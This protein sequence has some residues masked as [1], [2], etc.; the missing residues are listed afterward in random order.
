MTLLV[1][2]IVDAAIVLTF[3]LGAV[4]VLQR[5]S[6]A[7]RH[8]ILAT[9][10][11]A[12]LLM[13][14][15]EW[16]LPPLPVLSWTD[17]LT[18]VSAGVGPT[19]RNDGF[20]PQ[21]TAAAGPGLSWPV[22]LLT[23][24]AVGAL[25]TGAG[26]LT[27]LVRLSRLLRRGAPVTDRRRALT[28]E[29]SRECGVTRHVSLVQSDDYSVLVTCGVFHPTIVLP[30]CAS[31]WRDDRT[32]IIL[33]HELAHIRRYD[34]AL[35]VAGEA[36]CA[37]HWIN[38]LA[39]EACRRLRHE[40]EYSCDDEVLNGGVE[41]TEYATHLLAVAKSLGTRPAAW[42][43]ALPIA[44]PSTLERRIATMFQT[45]QSRAP[46]G[47]RGWCVAALGALSVSIPLAAIA[48][49]ERTLVVL[50]ESRGVPLRTEAR[51][52]AIDVGRTEVA[53]RRFTPTPRRSEAL[54]IASA[55]PLPQAPATLEVTLSD[56]TG[57]V[58]PGVQMTLTDTQ[59]GTA[60]AVYTNGAGQ[61]IIRDLAPGQYELVARLAGFATVTTPLTVGSGAT[62]QGT[63]RLPLGTLRETV[64]V[65]CPP[66]A[67]IG[68]PAGLRPDRLVMGAVA[69]LFPALSAQ[70]LPVRVGGVVRPPARVRDVVPIC[71]PGA[72]E[73]ETRVR[74]ATRMGVDGVLVD[75][76]PVLADPGAAPPAAALVDAAFDAVRQWRFTPAFLNGQPSEVDY[77]VDVVFNKR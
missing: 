48:P 47:R 15:F 24:W 36:L 73:I 29:L 74:F 76:T 9:A 10:I 34:V 31:T 12:A 51:A 71:P 38:P 23:L 7:L 67:A 11:V 44:L 69:A 57:G 21:A 5:R 70:Q 3:G 19:A 66:T 26:L 68:L 62:V 2:A 61:S 58:L 27:D 56:Q 65:G 72:Y 32:R 75:V 59:T 6:A 22:V 16:L 39:W 49:A 42:V 64:W 54:R 41:A 28:E 30:A 4:I 50:P 60:R 17:H 63:I 33:R 55:G 40:S 43:S 45:Q 14:A 1:A 13:P 37:L 25:A 46:F 77:I 35:Q 53:G 52:I 18:V 8:A 20:G